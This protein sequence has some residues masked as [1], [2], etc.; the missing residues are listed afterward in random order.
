MVTPEASRALRARTIT[1]SRSLEETDTIE[2]SS[3]RRI[4]RPAGF[5]RM[6]DAAKH[7]M[8]DE[9][10]QLSEEEQ[11][12]GAISSVPTH[13]TRYLQWIYLI[14]RV[15]TFISLLVGCRSRIYRKKHLIRF[16]GTKR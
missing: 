10:I 6:V 14:E 16:Q 13:L 9:I 1:T 12:Y 15:K 4:T 5:A 11:A 3:V 8:I 2:T 7:T